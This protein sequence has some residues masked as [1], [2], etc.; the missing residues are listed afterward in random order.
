MFHF[1]NLIT[2]CHCWNNWVSYSV[3]VVILSFLWSMGNH[4]CWSA[5][6]CFCISLIS[7]VYWN[8]SWRLVSMS[9]ICWNRM[10]SRGR[11]LVLDFFFFLILIVIIFRS[12]VT[13]NTSRHHSRI[14]SVTTRSSIKVISSIHL[15]EVIILLNLNIVLSISSTSSSNFILV[16]FFKLCF[17]SFLNVNWH[18]SF[19]LLLLWSLSLP[20]KIL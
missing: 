10:M 6:T 3:L 5:F 16:V 19:V 2:W 1:L 12:F 7:W 9:S 11:W 4:I 17:L 8:L 15:T 20:L 13:S 14:S 18:C